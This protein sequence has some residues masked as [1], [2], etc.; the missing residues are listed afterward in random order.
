MY[1]KLRK[2]FNHYK[3]KGVCNMSNKYLDMYFQHKRN[4]LKQNFENPNIAI[5]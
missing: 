4:V 1:R 2:N 5:Q 3:I